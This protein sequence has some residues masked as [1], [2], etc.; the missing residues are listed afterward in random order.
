MQDVQQWAS[1][2]SR[3]GGDSVQKL[4]LTP[5]VGSNG[6]N[7]TITN[8]ASRGYPMIDQNVVTQIRKLQSQAL[9]AFPTANPS[10]SA[11]GG[12]TC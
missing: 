8:W 11:S 9:G 7:L 1:L 4:V 2:A 12:P 5:I 3:V 6:G 10:A